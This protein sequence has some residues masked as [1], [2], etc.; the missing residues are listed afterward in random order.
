MKKTVIQNKMKSLLAMVLL[1]FACIPAALAQETFNVSGTIINEQ[2][3]PM[4]GVYVLEKGT[5]NGTSSDIDGHYTLTVRENATLV[6]SYIGYVV[7]ERLVTASVID[8]TL[9]EDAQALDEVVV[10]GYGV[11]KKSD[12]TGAISQVKSD[13][14][15]NRSITTV[16]DGLLGKTAGVQVVTT[17][18]A[19]GAQS[20]IRI[21]GYSSNSD[22]TPLYI[23]D[24][25]RTSNMHIW[26]RLILSRLKY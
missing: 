10:I 20:S 23:V 16:E 7:Q 3:E 8:V 11:Q 5:T 24:G 19:P 6:F 14:L 1:F 9:R 26:I 4:I 13:D 2:N 17:S 15:E 18:G 21:R 12:L 25:L 22:S